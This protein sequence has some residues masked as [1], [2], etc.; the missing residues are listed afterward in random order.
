MTDR[1]GK[2]LL[3]FLEWAGKKGLMNVNSANALRGTCAKLLEINDG[4]ETSDVF[5]VD[6]DALMTRFQNLRGK[7]YKPD[8]LDTY[9][10]R[11][12]RARE[13]YGEYLDNPTGWKG[14]A[15]QQPRPR[16]KD[17]AETPRQPRSSQPSGAAPAAAMPGTEFVEYPF[18][19]RPDCLVRLTLPTD[20]TT[21]EAKRL[22]AFIAALSV[23]SAA[24]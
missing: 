10:K 6:L 1:S 17:E 5:S 24:A 18:P 21:E 9:R 14:A 16:R 15:T 13:L 4:W 8:T 11:F 2:A 7:E 12:E 19:L 20:L 3:D 22:S 23:D